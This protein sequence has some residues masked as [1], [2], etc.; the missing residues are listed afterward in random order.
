[1]R[2]VPDTAWAV[3]TIWQEA[4]GESAAGKLAVARVIR[5][6]MARHYF[7]D[8]T[9]T[10]TVLYPYQ[11]SGWNSKEP[12]RLKAAVL[13]ATALDVE[14]CREAW[15]RSATDDAGIRGAV[16]YYAPLVVTETPAWAVPEKQV[17]VI[18]RH[19]FFTA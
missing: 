14:A 1:M 13:D 8:G 5:N 6:R 2:L 12:N 17:A 7:S 18:G 19:V 9:V 10:G 15:D 11:F 3:M 16:L 4:R